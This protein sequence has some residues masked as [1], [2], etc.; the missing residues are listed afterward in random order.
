[1]KCELC[2]ERMG[3][4]KQ[5]R[6]HGTVKRVRH[7]PKDLNVITTLEPCAC[8]NCGGIESSVYFTDSGKDSIIRG[9]TCSGCG[10]RFQTLETEEV[11]E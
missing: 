7:C 10:R 6:F 2:D 11:A 3:I 5:R 4:L 8:P 9:R 1:M